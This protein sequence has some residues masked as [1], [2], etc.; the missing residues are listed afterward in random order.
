ML[1]F[2]CS[3]ST[4]RRRGFGTSFH[5]EARYACMHGEITHVYACLLCLICACSRACACAGVFIC[6]V[7]FYRCICADCFTRN[8]SS[9]LSLPLSSP[10]FM[11]QAVEMVTQSASFWILVGLHVLLWQDPQ[12]WYWNLHTHA[13]HQ[14]HTLQSQTVEKSWCCWHYFIRHGQ[15]TLMEA[16]FSNLTTSLPKSAYHTNAGW[17]D[18]IIANC[19]RDG[20]LLRRCP[21]LIKT[22]HIY[23]H[24][25]IHISFCGISLYLYMYM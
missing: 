11:F 19:M 16:L 12:T 22:R 15:E 17:R 9:T 18:F 3:T 14:T 24:I 21:T 5:T 23:I 2:F 4:M 10:S 20:M 8:R 7:I 6:I 1:L 13:T 25:Y